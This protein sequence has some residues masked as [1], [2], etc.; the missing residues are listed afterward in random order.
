[1]IGGVI[2]CIPENQER[3]IK[4]SVIGMLLSQEATDAYHLPRLFS[5]AIFRSYAILGVIEMQL[6]TLLY[7]FVDLH[8]DCYYY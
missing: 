2:L 8:C 6:L 5:D 7:A 3:F 1:M 4:H